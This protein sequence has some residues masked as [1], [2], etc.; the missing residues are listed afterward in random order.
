MKLFLIISCTFCLLNSNSEQ[1]TTS[2]LSLQDCVRIALE[3]NLSLKSKE[4]DVKS[5]SANFRSR[6]SDFLPSVS[7]YS[8]YNKSESQFHSA[9]GEYY[10]WEGKSY[11]TSLSLHQ[12]VFDVSTLNYAAQSKAERDVE[13]LL[14]TKKKSD[15]ILEVKGDYYNLLKARKLLRVAEKAL[16][17]SEQNLDKTEELYK[18]GSASRADMLKAKVNFLEN[19]LGLLTATKSV[20]L[21]QS[22]LCNTIGFPPDS[23]I[24]V[25]E[26]SLVDAQPIPDIDS[27]MEIATRKNP[28]ILQST[29]GVSL[30]RIALYSAFGEYLPSISISARYGVE[31]EDFPKSK[32]IWD[33]SRKTWSY[34]INVSLPIFTSFQRPSGVQ[35]A[36]SELRKANYN[37]QNVEASVLMQIR[38]CCLTIEEAE[39]RMNLTSESRELAEESYRAAKERYALGAASILEL[40]DAEVAQLQAESWS[41][42]ALYD[43]KLAWERL[44]VVVG[45]D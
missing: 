24:Y 38:E 41:I 12:T 43:Y 5:A 35:K 31:G 26:D 39:E 20:K 28:D 23:S 15:I 18:L 33:S 3:K 37:N 25:A 10:T 36:L 11:T 45:E 40:I 8:G 30:A 14:Y 17:E 9:S 2:K 32:E 6:W 44:K 1:G 16:K 22:M 7:L 4:E 42:E 21:S 27:L 29:A 19:K 34:G 13:R